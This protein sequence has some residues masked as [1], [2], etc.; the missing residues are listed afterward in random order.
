MITE[1]AGTAAVPVPGAASGGTATVLVVEDDVLLRAAITGHLRGRGLVVLE[2]ASAEEA[3]DLLRTPAV[4]V[5]FTDVLLDGPLTGADLAR[6]I[7]REHPQVEVLLTSAVPDEA[8]GD[9]EGITLL[10]KPYRLF[11]V[12]H[13]LQE[14]LSRSQREQA[15]EDGGRAAG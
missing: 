12:E 9:L 1:M 5:V 4:R 6:S 3:L 11:Q 14:L 10:A 8:K 7:R 13:H 2:A 15:T